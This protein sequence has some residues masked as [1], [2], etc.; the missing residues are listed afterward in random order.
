VRGETAVG[1]AGV[2]MVNVPGVAAVPA[3]TAAEGQRRAKLPLPDPG[4]PVPGLSWPAMGVFAGAWT[5]WIVTAWAVSARHLG[6]WWTIPLSAAASFAMFTVLHDAAHYSISRVRWVNGLTGRLAMLLVAAYGSFPMFSYI[7]IQHHR[8]ANDDRTDPDTWASHGPGWQLLL[9]WATIDFRYAVFYLSKRRSRPRAETLEG[10]LLLLAG[11]A[12]MVAASWMGVMRELAVMYLIPQRIALMVLGWWFDW[13]P[14]HGLPDT[15][16][17]NRYR[18]TRVRVGLEWFYTPLMLSQNY[19]LVHHLHPSI[20]FHRYLR[21]W[22]RNEDAYLD[23]GVAIATVIGQQLSPDEYRVYRHLDSPLARLRPVRA[24]EGSSSPYGVFYRLRVAH[25]AY[26]TNDSVAITFAV[27]DEMRGLFRFTHGQHVTVRTDLGGHGVRRNYS[28]CS[29]ATSARLRIAVKAIPGG[30]FSSFAMTQLEVGD[31]LELMTPQGCFGTALDPL[32]KKHYV[33]IAAGSGITPILSI[34]ATTL[35]IEADSRFTLIYGNRTRNSTM[36]RGELDELASRYADRL[37][38]KHVLSGEPHRDLLLTGRIDRP[39]LETWL[40]EELRPGEVDEWFL[41]GPLGLIKTARE[42]LV[43]HG[44]D[45]KHIHL[46]L[47]YGY[48]T[49][50]AGGTLR[51]AQPATVTMKLGGRQYTFGLAPRQSVLEGVLGVRED[52]PYSCMGGACGTCRAKLL[53]GTVAME[54][55]FALGQDALDQGY[56][57]TCQAHATSPEIVIDFDAQHSS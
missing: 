7:H 20:P 34:L 12:V 35:E 5:T 57:L 44:V 27:P 55:N 3:S 22:R 32:H 48:D 6:W 47:F 19:H 21:T 11:I 30:A 16:L 49:A 53:S 17:E 31:E 29:P 26:P 18:A 38:I 36:F 51:D 37:E 14:H 33:A 52:A 9:R 24:P 46:E 13:L 50:D 28:I 25:I 2:E 56:V 43:A 15:Q 23:R 8:A 45:L 40:V 39:K 54:H 42:T 41:C 4:E 1:S 10:G